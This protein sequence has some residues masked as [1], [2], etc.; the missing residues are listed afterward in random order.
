MSTMAHPSSYAVNSWGFA[1]NWTAGYAT[2]T[3]KRPP[4]RLEESLT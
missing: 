3:T 4:Q 1:A 2:T